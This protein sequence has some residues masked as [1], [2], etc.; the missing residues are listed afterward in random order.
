MGGS[1]ST[2]NNEQPL[3]SL[4]SLLNSEDNAEVNW[5]LVRQILQQEPEQACLYAHNVEA[6]QLHVALTKGAPLDI[7]RLLVDADEDALLLSFHGA[8]VLHVAQD[9]PVVQ[10]LLQQSPSLA[11]QR[12]LQGCLPLHTCRNAQ[13]AQQLIQAHPEG[14]TQRSPRSGSLPLHHALLLEGAIIDSQL[15]QV[16]TPSRRPNHAILTRNK[17]GQMPL[18]LLVD[19]L[20]EDPINDDL[21]KVLLEWTR[22]LKLP[23]QTELHTLI[24]YGCCNSERLMDRALVDLDAMLQAEKR[25]N[26]GRTPLHVAASRGSCSFEALERLLQA[27]PKAPRMTDNEGRLP[28]DWAAESPNTQLRNLS[29]LMKGEPR[30]ID[31][32]DLRDGHY[33]F[34]SAALSGDQANINTTYYLLRAKPHVLKYFHLP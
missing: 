16:L 26:L 8:T 27:N 20:D 11:Q 1:Q 9:G 7:V 2:T 17:Q 33:P 21:W 22:L 15:L 13:A 23:Q 34:V 10:Y 14:A 28:I 19:R 12:D 3:P 5:A 31:T 4:S 18:Q 32:R 25:D 6:S 24:D 30:A 29:L